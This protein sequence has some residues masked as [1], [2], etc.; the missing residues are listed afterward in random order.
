MLQKMNKINETQNTYK[1]D[2]SNLF[3]LCIGKPLLVFSSGHLS[4][5]DHKNKYFYCFPTHFGC[6]FAYNPTK[7]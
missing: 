1:P 2:N 4:R 3:V 5:S 7:T 6:A